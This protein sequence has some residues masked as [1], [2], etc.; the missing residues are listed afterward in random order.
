VDDKGKRETEIEE[1]TKI[2]INRNGERKRGRKS[3]TDKL[4]RKKMENKEIHR[5]KR[6]IGWKHR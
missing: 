1:G 2:D 4:E 5:N 3:K 6:Y